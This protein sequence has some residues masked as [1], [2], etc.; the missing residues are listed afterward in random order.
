LIA[1]CS[2]SAQVSI[3]G[4]GSSADASAM[5]EVKSTEK[6]FYHQE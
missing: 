4:D 3:T 1:S 6:V 2:L 5:L